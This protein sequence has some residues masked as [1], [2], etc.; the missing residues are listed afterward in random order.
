MITLFWLILRRK[1]NTILAL[2]RSTG[3]GRSIP[4]G[5]SEKRINMA[6]LS[7]VVLAVLDLDPLDILVT[8]NRIFI[9]LQRSF[10][11]CLGIG[12]STFRMSESL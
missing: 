12:K 4:L 8:S 7:C 3:I 6:G 9:E 10:C 2:E 1:R 5:S 11:E